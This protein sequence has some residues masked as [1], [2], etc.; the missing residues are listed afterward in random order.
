GGWLTRAAIRDGAETRC[1]A[2]WRRT[3][4]EQGSEAPR[5]PDTF[6]EQHLQRT[7]REWTLAGGGSMFSV[8]IWS[9]EDSGWI[10]VSRHQTLEAADKAAVEYME[11][12][13]YTTAEVFTAEG[14]FAHE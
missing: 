6:Q 14:G 10:V 1:P 3:D 11:A 12:L 8:R 13:P 5:E 2:A 9:A 4:Q 7:S